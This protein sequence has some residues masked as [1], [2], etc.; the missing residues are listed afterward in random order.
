MLPPPDLFIPERP[1]RR[2]QI[3]DWLRRELVKMRS[4]GQW[5]LRRKKAS[6][7]SIVVVAFIVFIFF[8]WP[9]A[10]WLVG[11]TYRKLAPDQQLAALAQVR[12][13]LLQLSGGMLAA[14]VLI[15]TGRSFRLSREGHVTD[16]FTKAIDQLGSDRLEVRL[17]G[18]YAL[19]RIMIDSARDRG[20]ISDILAAFVREHSPISGTDLAD[21]RSRSSNET[22]ANND[23]GRPSTDVQAALTVLARRSGRPNEKK[24]A[25]LRYTDLRGADLQ[26]ASFACT[27]LVGTDL[28]N[29]NLF[30]IDL[31]NA[32]LAGADLRDSILYNSC[33]DGADL[34]AANLKRAKLGGAHLRGSCLDNCNLRSAYLVQADLYQAILYEADLCDA[35][36]NNTSF[37]EAELAGANLQKASLNQSD[38]RGAHLRNADLSGAHLEEV[39]VGEAR[40]DGADLR[41]ACVIDT[42]LRDANLAGAN[43]STA[44]GLTQD[45]IATATI[46]RRTKLPSGLRLN[47]STS[48]AE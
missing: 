45:Q 17:G 11:S 47:G 27:N 28:R 46:N 21:K 6:I 3:S 20:A 48:S 29:A 31:T 39:Y 35:N 19:E 24:I 25:D 30:A 40:G 15:Y 14:G 34:T 18:I 38:L 7:T 13:Q 4:A 8:L 44:E 36:L 26:H 42:I 10:M 12:S 1:T 37:R 9:G 22:S 16:R 2:R 32:Q 23:A 5:L 33:L 41:G 43:L